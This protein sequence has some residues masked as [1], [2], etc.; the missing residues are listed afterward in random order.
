MT[1]NFR[2]WN[3][4][5]EWLKKTGF[6]PTTIVD[7]GV[8][9]DT[10]ELYHW[11]PN[12]NFIFVEPL[13]EFEPS[14]QHL[15]SKYRGNYILAAAGAYDGEIDLEVSPDLGGSSI[16]KHL[17]ADDKQFEEA[18]GMQPFIPRRV[19]IFRLDTIWK[20]FDATGPAILKVDVQGGEI[21]VL[22]GA[23]ECLDNFEIVIIEAGISQTYENQPVL[24]DHMNYMDQHGFYIIDFINAGYNNNG[25]LCE[26]D[27]VFA[28][29]KGWLFENNQNWLDYSKAKTWDN[30]K[31]IRRQ[32]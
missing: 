23:Q 30:Y 22:K 24:I 14:L 8:A 4:F 26:V 6:A 7:V 21:E 13:K 12:S 9:T 18:L 29:K 11:Y 1:T 28:R 25:I 32:E 15:V 2:N 19:P 10:E 5:F 20:A 16:F 27:A 17:N 31:G 3:R